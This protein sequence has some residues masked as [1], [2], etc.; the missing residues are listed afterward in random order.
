M[1][2]LCRRTK[3]GS[4]SEREGPRGGCMRGVSH[5]GALGTVSSEMFYLCKSNVEGRV[6]PTD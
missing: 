3:L 6:R 5:G 2:V 4:V 1:L